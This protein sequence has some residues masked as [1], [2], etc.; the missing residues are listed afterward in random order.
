[1]HPALTIARSATFGVLD[2][3]RLITKREEIKNEKC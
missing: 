1:M 3:Y 2:Q